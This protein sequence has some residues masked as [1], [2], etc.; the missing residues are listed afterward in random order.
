MKKT[1]L[2]VLVFLM[3][4]CGAAARRRPRQHLWASGSE[5]LRIALPW[6]E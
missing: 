6:V 5:I 3:A 1:F 4:A 2:I